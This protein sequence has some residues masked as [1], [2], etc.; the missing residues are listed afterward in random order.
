[1][2]INK[3]LRYLWPFVKLGLT[4]VWRH[5]TRSFLTMLG[6]VFG[7]GS[8]VAMLAVGE[9][10]SQQSIDSIKKLGSENIMVMS[11]KPS[12]ENGGNTGQAR[13]RL[14]VYGLLYDDARR[15]A[16]TV[17]GVKTIVS[18]RM[19]QRVAR[20]GERQLEMRV[21]ETYPNWFEVVH[22]PV[23][24]GRVLTDRD[25]S[26]RANVCVL[27]EHGVR[28]LLA[29]EA[30]VGQ[31]IRIASGV[32]EVIGIVQNE[33]GGTVRAPDSEAD[34]YIPLTTG[35]K[36]F[37]EANIRYSAGGM[38]GE[39]VELSEVI[40]RMKSVEV[41]EA[42]SKAIEALLKRFHKKPDYKIDVP[43]TL[44]RETERSKRTFNIVLGA[45]AGISLL[46]GGIGIMNIMLASVTERTK[47][48]GIRRAIGARKSLIVVQFL[49][50]TCV[51]SIIGGV[52]GLLVG[53]TIPLLV[54]LFTS[55]PTLVE[56]YSLILAF[57]ISVGIG[58]VFGLYPAMRAAALDPIEALRYE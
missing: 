5:K 18:A 1:M 9:G 56:P 8:V 43:L 30:M 27:T 32:F 21:V 28:R 46:V 26:M 35:T 12:S 44:L 38:E 41:V 33:T 31:R 20:M 4:D 47:E 25:L 17:P 29:G 24:D 50:N 14:A 13:G 15:I 19:T 7:V 39:K 10:A 2:Q 52:V 55:M 22:R 42:G 53:V 37:G 23:L 54:T 49:I 48:I 58:I 34:A 3:R 11:V 57:G 6:M 40:V 16:E 51:L 36:L 45:I